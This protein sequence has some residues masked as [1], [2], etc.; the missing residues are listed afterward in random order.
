MTDDVVTYRD[1]RLSLGMS[2]RE[3]LRSELEIGYVFSRDLS[4]RSG[5]GD[6]APG[7]TVMVRSSHRY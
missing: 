7:D 5:V 1:L 4:Y 2:G 3:Q 6:F